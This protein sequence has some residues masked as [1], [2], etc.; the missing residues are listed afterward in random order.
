MGDGE[1]TE[2]FMRMRS[3]GNTIPDIVQALEEASPDMAPNTNIPVDDERVQELLD[4][5]NRRPDEEAGTESDIVNDLNESQRV[6]QQ[7]GSGLSELAEGENEATGTAEES[8]ISGGGGEGGDAPTPPSNEEG[9]DDDIAGQQGGTLEVD[10]T[11]ED[12]FTRAEDGSPV[13][14]E[15]QGVVTENTVLDI[16][17]RELPDEATSTLTE[18]ERDVIFSQVIEEAVNR[19]QTP[20]ELQNLVRNYF[21]RLTLANEE[22]T[23][24]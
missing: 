15:I 13:L 7:M 23:N 11:F 1:I 9:G 14:R 5:L 12:D 4:Q 17:I 24:E 10:D 8:G 16:L 2:M 21:F 19:E 3:E 22:G 18:Q 6:L 20:P